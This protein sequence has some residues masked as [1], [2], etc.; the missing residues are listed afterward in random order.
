VPPPVVD[1]VFHR[2]RLR[3]VIAAIVVGIVAD[4]LEHHPPQH[5]VARRHLGRLRR[6]RHQRIHGLRIFHA[7]DPAMHAAHRIANHQPEVFYAEP[8]LDQAMLRIDHVLVIV[9]R[10][11]RLRAVGGF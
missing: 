2:A 9:F 8:F 6:H 10:K 1:G 3:G 4:G 11:R 5:P 7:P